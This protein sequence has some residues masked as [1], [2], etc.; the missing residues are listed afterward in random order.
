MIRMAR[1]DHFRSLRR[2]AAGI[3]RC[4]RHGA[5]AAV[6]GLVLAG[7]ATGAFGQG[8]PVRAEPVRG[9]AM[10]QAN[11]GFARLVNKHSVDV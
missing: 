2:A 1:R 11:G 4:C 6:L 10:L 5:L 3:A 8:E 7:T 9:E